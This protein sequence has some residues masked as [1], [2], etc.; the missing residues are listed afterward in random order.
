MIRKENFIGYTGMWNLQ[1]Q[2]KNIFIYWLQ[3]IFNRYVTLAVQ[4]REY[5]VLGQANIN[6]HAD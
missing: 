6:V 5:S 4:L 1:I 2:L 3:N